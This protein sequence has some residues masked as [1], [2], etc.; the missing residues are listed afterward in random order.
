MAMEFMVLTGFVFDRMERVANLVDFSTMGRTSMIFGLFE[1]GVSLTG[2]VDSLVSDGGCK[3]YTAPR[4]CHTRKHVLACG[5]SGV[6]A[7][8]STLC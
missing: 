1:T 4:T 2:N 6:H 3:Q 7:S 8:Q 5:S